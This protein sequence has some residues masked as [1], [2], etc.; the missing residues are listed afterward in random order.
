ML[1]RVDKL[2][3]GK[4]ISRT[5]SLILW[6]ADGTPNLADGEIVVLDKDMKIMIAGSTISDTDTIYIIQGTGDTYSYADASG[7]AVTS[8]RRFIVSDPIEGALV[9]SWKGVSYDAKGEQVSD[10]DVTGM[11]PVVGTEYVVRIVYKDIKEH[12]GQF[13]QTYRYISTTATLGTFTTAFAAV[14]NAH[15][16]CRVVATRD[17]TSI[18]LTGKPIPECTTAVTD[19]DKFSQVSFDAVYYY[20]SV[21]ADSTKGYWIEWPATTVVQT[22]TAADHGQGTWEQL[23]DLEKAQKSYRGF[24]NRTTFPILEPTTYTDKTLTYDLLVIESNKSYVSSDAWVKQAPLT[25]IVALVVDSG[26]APNV[27][28]VLNPWFASCPGVF[29]NV[30][31]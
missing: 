23:R 7:D 19:I 16:G 8:V 25:T 2:L 21:A 11:T 5:G 4:D 31:V 26:Q 6:K 12:P 17:A 30:D 15:A 13:T 22:I 24:T 29:A 28:N 20:I 3:I 14:I 9:K 27:L 1:K 18:I 10:L